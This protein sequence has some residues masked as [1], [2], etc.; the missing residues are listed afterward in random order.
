[1]KNYEELTQ[2][3]KDLFNLLPDNIETT[4]EELKEFS[5]TYCRYIAMNECDEKEF[6]TVEENRWNSEKESF[7]FFVSIGQIKRAKEELETIMFK[8][9]QLSVAN[10]Y[11]NTYLDENQNKLRKSKGNLVLDIE[12]VPCRKTRILMEMEKEGHGTMNH[13]VFEVARLT[14]EICGIKVKSITFACD[15]EKFAKVKLRKNK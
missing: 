5:D 13:A 6:L 12:K 1:M 3:S 9:F 10:L 2:A 8:Q 15:G 7:E 4:H 11:A 14:K